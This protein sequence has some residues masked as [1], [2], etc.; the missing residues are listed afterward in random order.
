MKRSLLAS[1]VFSVAALGMIVA[2]AVAQEDEEAVQQ[3]VTVTGTRIQKDNLIF[4]SP[5]TAVTAQDVKTQ[6]VTRIEDL[7]TQLPQAFAAQNSTVANGASGTAT[8]DLRNLGASRTLVLIDGRRMPYGSPSSIPA[9]LNTIPTQLVERVDVLTGGA[10]A[11]YGSDAIAGVVNFIMKDDFE[12]FQIDAQYSFYQHNNDYD[13]NGDLRDVISGRSASNPSQFRVPDDNV[14]DGWGKEITMM[15]GV[16]SPDDRGNITA[17]ATYRNNDAVLQGERD[18]SACAIGRATATGFTCGGSSTSFP[19]RVNNTFFGFGP[20]NEDINGEV[21]AGFDFTLAD[22]G[23]IR[24]FNANTD[25]YNF[26][27]LNYYQRPD[28]RYN[29]GAFGRYQINENAEVY[30]QLMF[31]DYETVAQI[32]P[33]GNFFSTE[34]LNC[35]NPLMS[36]DFAA[37]IGC[38]AADI[39]SNSTVNAFFGRRNVEGGGR[40]DSLRFTNYRGVVGLRGDMPEMTGWTYDLTAQYAQTNQT[41]TYNN[42]F[43]ISRLGNAVNVVTDPT[44]GA[45]VCQSVLDGTDPNCVPYNIFNLGGV[46]EEALGY[47]QVPLAQSGTTTQ[48]ILTAALT[49]DLGQYG[50]KSPAADTGL[51]VVLGAETRRETLDRVVDVTF[52]TGDGAGQGGATLPVEGS[53]SNVDIFGEA[54]FPLVEGRPGIELLSIDAAY[55]YSTYDIGVEASSFKVGAEYAP[56]N[57]VRLRG[58]FQRATRAPNVLELFTSQG[59]NLFDADQDPCGLGGNAT[60]ADCVATGVP[61]G[62]FGSAGLNSP[63]GQ[64]NFLQGG[65]PNLDPEE[66]DTYT[67]GIV[68]TPTM[69]PAF[70]ASIDYYNI[71]ITDRIDIVDPNITLDLCY[72]SGDQ[73]ACDRIKRSSGGSLW[74]SNDGFVE[75]LNTNIGGQATSG[76]DFNA[77]YAFDLDT[78]GSFNVNMIGTYLLENETDPIGLDEEKFDCAGQFA[79]ACGVPQPEWRHRARVSWE[80]PYDVTLNGTWRYYGGVD[81]FNN[82]AD[83][84]DASFDAENYFDIAG[85]YN[86]FDNTVVRAGINNVLDND[87]QLSASVGTTGNGNT[88]PQLY[89]ALGRYIFMGVTVDF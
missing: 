82:T 89:D 26:G 20:G 87:P 56:T 29:L 78:M 36:A 79:G 57:D 51:Q 49:G 23:G 40:Q 13:T 64:F 6:G 63:A 14:S 59:L 47:V 8:V 62:L 19:G 30:T 55:R 72:Q 21:P 35:G 25:Q 3:T 1:S 10:S 84:V 76:I 74:V 77:A 9:D 68:L 46:T 70:T 48:Q 2:P 45:A 85:T 75:G 54:L 81:L 71:E 39:A 73:A 5:V 52:A 15:M 38:D 18:Y 27:P 16:N 24:P 50:L 37:G 69:L 12:G 34:T 58:S 42:E 33:S 65:N 61:A 7:V 44:T 17:Y 43:S 32:A 86:L 28:E 41:R 53:V 80:T 4:T 66:A 88:Y 83:R 60:L 31:T 11:V 22:G 67:V